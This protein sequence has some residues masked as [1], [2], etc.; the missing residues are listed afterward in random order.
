[1]ADAF[2]PPSVRFPPGAVVPKLW[3]MS[4]RRLPDHL[5]ISDTRYF[6]IHLSEF[7]DFCDLVVS[8]VLLGPLSCTAHVS[9]LGYHRSLPP[10]P[11]FGTIAV[12]IK[13][14]YPRNMQDA[15]LQHLMRNG[16]LFELSLAEIKTI[17]VIARMNKEKRAY[18]IFNTKASASASARSSRN[19]GE[20]HDTAPLLEPQS[21]IG[22]LLDGKGFQEP[23]AL[24]SRLREFR[25]I[26]EKVLNLY[27]K[28]I[29]NGEE[30]PIR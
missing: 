22:A 13:G 8:Y 25:P 6:W 10:Y 3:S 21:E 9:V 16:A 12:N 18:S 14:S 19:A 20:M 30:S 11:E 5:S 17:L 7:S 4:D 27:E 1:M 23:G 24:G 2:A 28:Y 15:A 29:V 26:L